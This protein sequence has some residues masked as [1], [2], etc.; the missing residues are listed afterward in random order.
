MK[1]LKLF[2]NFREND[3]VEVN[4]ER[5]R[6]DSIDGDIVN[7]R[8]FKGNI[9][10]P[11]DKS[12]VNKVKRCMARCFKQVKTDKDGNRFVYCSGCDRITKRL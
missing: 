11:F 9:I 3:M 6:V 2:E 10:K 7:V 4:G 1:Y 12:S 5:G 8:L